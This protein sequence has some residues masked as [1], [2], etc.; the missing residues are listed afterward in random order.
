[1]PRPTTKLTTRERDKVARLQAEQ[2]AENAFW[3]S[4]GEEDLNITIREGAT[5]TS[6]HRNYTSDEQVFTFLLT[7][8]KVLC[9]FKRSL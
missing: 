2:N 1:M 8:H 3:S 6:Y 4:A 5:L 7:T 9:I